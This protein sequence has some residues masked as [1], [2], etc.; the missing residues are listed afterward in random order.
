MVV[1]IIVF[2]GF[3]KPDVLGHFREEITRVHNY[4]TS[5]M[6]MAISQRFD[7]FNTMTR[8]NVAKMH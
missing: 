1:L 7:A 5:N 2:E 6:T 8:D 3:Y 4:R